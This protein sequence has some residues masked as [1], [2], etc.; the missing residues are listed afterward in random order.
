MYVHTHECNGPS[1]AYT[2]GQPSRLSEA[3]R[4]PTQRGLPADNLMANTENRYVWR[5]LFSLNK[6]QTYAIFLL[7]F[8]TKEMRLREGG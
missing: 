5:M 1:H 3:S 2:D 7:F 8:Q 4:D 6:R